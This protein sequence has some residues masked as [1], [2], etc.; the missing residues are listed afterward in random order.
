MSRLWNSSEHTISQKTLFWIVGYAVLFD[1]LSAF[2]RSTQY[3]EIEL[4][5]GNI[6]E[7]YAVGQAGDPSL[8]IVERKQ[9]KQFSGIPRG[10]DTNLPKECPAPI[11]GL[12]K[13]W[14]HVMVVPTAPERCA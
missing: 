14:L 2:R 5:T 10:W 12:D 8:L 9:P 1:Q 11:D 4:R 13:R 3:A 7:I 6:V